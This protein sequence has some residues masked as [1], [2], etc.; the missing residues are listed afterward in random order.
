MNQLPLSE[1]YSGSAYGRKENLSFLAGLKPGR[2]FHIRIKTIC[3]NLC[4][5]FFLCHLN[6]LSM[7]GQD[8]GQEIIYN[9]I[10]FFH[11][12]L[13]PRT[14]APRQGIL[15][16]E[17]KG[18]I[19]IYP[20]FQDALKSLELFEYIIVLYHF[21]GIKGW[22]NSANP[23]GS[24]QDITFGLFSTRSPARPNPIG[25]A[26]IKLEKIEKGILFVSGIDAY[27]GTPVLDIKPYLP[28][29]DCVRS[30]RNE[31][32]EKELGLQESR[33]AK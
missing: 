12:P 6:I 9:P 27:D 26:V 2:S 25:L 28:S 4:L 24:N 5:M 19:E 18:T 31:M 15:N 20:Q 29:I 13:T 22:K 32:T 10:G 7:N 17:I 8:T 16:P 23:P 21:N 1:C 11:S 33:N 3:I 14:G 30:N